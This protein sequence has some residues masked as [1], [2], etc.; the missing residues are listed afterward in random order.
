M[1]VRDLYEEWLSGDALAVGR[2]VMEKLTPAQQVAR[3]IAVL[4]HM[5]FGTIVLVWGARGAF[6]QAALYDHPKAARRRTR[7]RF[8]R[9]T[10]NERKCAIH[11]ATR[12]AG[13]QSASIV[14]NASIF[15]DQHHGP[16]SSE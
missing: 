10:T 6:A 11:S 2:S 14:A 3:C 9:P 5:A 12:H 7:T 1:I 15:G 8:D 4:D 13:T 16:T